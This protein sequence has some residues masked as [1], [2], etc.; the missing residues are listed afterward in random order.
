M[1]KTYIKPIMRVLLFIV[2]FVVFTALSSGITIFV[3]NSFLGDGGAAVALQLTMFFSALL[4]V[5]LYLWTQN[6]SFKDIGI[7]W[8][9]KWYLRLLRGSLEG[10]AAIL[11]SAAVLLGLGLAAVRGY[12]AVQPGDIALKL[13]SGFVRYMLVVAFVEEAITRGYI[14]HYLKSKFTVAG[15]V[16]LTSFIFMLMHI[17]NPGVTGLALFNIFLLG[18]VLNLLVLRDRNL[19][20]AIGFHFGWN[21]AMGTILSIPVSGGESLGVIKL[22]MFGNELLTGG[23]FGLEG[24]LLCTA[25]LFTI[26]GYIL[27]QSTSARLMVK[28]LRL[29]KNLIFSGALVALTLVYLSVN[30]FV[31]IPE[32]IHSDETQAFR[33]LG[34]TNIH[35]YSMALSLDT[36][37]KTLA[38]LQE[39]SYINK[40]GDTLEEIY[41]HIYANGYRSNNGGIDIK[42]I[43][44]DGMPAGFAYEGDDLTLLRVDLPN[45][46]EPGNRAD[47]SMVY[48]IQIPGKGRRGVSDRFGYGDN[49]FNLG[50]FFPIASVYENGNWD[51]HIYDTKGDAFHSE[52]SNFSV[53]LTTPAKHIVASTGII[54]STET[55]ENSTIWN[56]KADSVRDFAFVSSDIFKVEEVVID[57]ILIKSYAGNRQ[58]ARKALEIGVESLKTFNRKFG[59]YPY[60]TCSIVQADISGGMEYPNLVMIGSK[61]YDN[62][63]LSDMTIN[64]YL[65]HKTL[66][67]FEFV[68]AH[69]LAHQWWYGLVGNDQYREAWIDEALTQYST[70]LYY[71]EKYG[72]EVMQKIYDRYIRAQGSMYLRSNAGRDNRLSRALSDFE[73][74]EYYILI[75][76]KGTMMFKDLHGRMGEEKF[77]QLLQELY[78]RYKYKIV[79]GHEL[80]E[81]ASEIAGKNMSDFFEQWLTTDYAGNE[82]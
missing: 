65:L 38:G 14:Y 24:G 21:Y 51:Q 25:V 69:E 42:S 8:G 54:E 34:P 27:W 64:K 15:A 80:I 61:S 1:Y 26:G 39:V 71:R 4:F 5:Y 17:F 40:T 31:W 50:N 10:T 6:K 18:V 59:R 68:I 3:F 41:F 52:V 12:G 72:P 75:Y 62:V 70:L 55:R 7:E 28:E 48:E 82:L 47:V 49:T 76:G 73:E 78:E 58:K 45:M 30:I 79:K 37:K 66:G 29:W 60:A 36:D 33:V 67:Q 9:A 44:I 19:W 16:L 35:N 46:L 22:S 53:Q 56:I 81:L 2:L 63:S 74:S 43:K 32:N 23:S 57:G 13:L 77:E 11:V 20:S